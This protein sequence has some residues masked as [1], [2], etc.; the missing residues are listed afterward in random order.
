[1]GIVSNPETMLDIHI[2]T[3]VREVC[4]ASDAKHVIAA[5]NQLKAF[6]LANFV[7]LR[8]VFDG[9]ER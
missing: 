6:I 3:L 2:D 7:P 5:Q 9:Q 8:K 1:M 4:F